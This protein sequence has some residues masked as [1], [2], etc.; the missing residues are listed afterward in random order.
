M[1]VT[2][3]FYNI[4]CDRCGA[5]VNEDTWQGDIQFVKYSAEGWKQLE[6]GRHICPECHIHEDDDSLTLNATKD[7]PVEVIESGDWISLG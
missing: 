5:L 3:T 7:L 4:K 6:D 1:V 2:E